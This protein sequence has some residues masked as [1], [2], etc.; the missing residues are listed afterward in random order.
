[1]LPVKGLSKSNLSNLRVNFFLFYVF[2][3]SNVKYCVSAVT[4]GGLVVT[5]QEISDTSVRLTKV[6][7]LGRSKVA[8]KL[9]D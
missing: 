7:Y 6:P 2:E 1:M 9:S 4:V 8:A 5:H 3:L